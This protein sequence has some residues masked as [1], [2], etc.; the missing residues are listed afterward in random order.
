MGK[1]NRPLFFVYFPK[2]FI[3]SF[4]G[5]NGSN[6]E[7]LGWL[8][9]L[10][11]SLVCCLLLGKVI[12]LLL[13]RFPFCKREFMCQNVFSTGSSTENSGNGGYLVI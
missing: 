3:F 10:I 7:W 12:L 2:S 5:G 1:E 13:L 8:P 4:L 6:G 11:L 9:I